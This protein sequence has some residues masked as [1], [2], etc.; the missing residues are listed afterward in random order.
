MRNLPQLDKINPAIMVDL[1][2]QTLEL[3]DSRL[4]DHGFRVAYIAGKT[5]AEM[6]QAL[7]Q[8]FDLKILLLLSLFHDTG[9]YKTEEINQ[10]VS[11]ETSHSLNHCV[12]GYL[13]LKHFTDFSEYSKVLL[14]HHATRQ[15]LANVSDAEFPYKH[16]S[17]L[18]HLAD[19]IDIASK[20]GMNPGEIAALLQLQLEKEDCEFEPDQIRAMLAY[21]L[22]DSLPTHLPV[23]ISH[24]YVHNTLCSLGLTTKEMYRFLNMLIHFID[25]KTP[26]TVY[27]SVTTA[28]IAAFLGGVSGQSQEVVND[29]YFAGLVHDIGKMGV[30]ATLIEYPGKLLPDEMQSVRS[31]VS[32][33][34]TLID[35]MLP[36]Q[37]VRLAARHHEKLNGSG[38]PLGLKGDQL[39]IPER[40]LTVSDITSALL[41]R[42]SYKANFDTEHTLSILDAMVAQGELDPQIV[43]L[44]HEHMDE[45]LEHITQV[46][47]PVRQDYEEIQAEYTQL[48]AAQ[49]KQAH[50]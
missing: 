8:Q 18:I 1:C 44:V 34:R 27:H 14:Y 23:E 29:L 17:L 43:Q 41:E 3:V 42:R 30:S 31:H 21:L 28:E 24:H 5:Y 38:Y 12:Y 36:P 11:F 50:P 15:Q 46:T 20:L 19:R 45:L 35:G 39:S 6:P 37:V 4:I 7:Q 49:A 47:R 9:A 48:V 10:M 32:I 26:S 22:H 13:F 25:F 2:S 40:I 16:Y 33:T